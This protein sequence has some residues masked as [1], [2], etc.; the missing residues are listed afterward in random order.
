M[1][2]AACFDISI[3]SVARSRKIK[4]TQQKHEAMARVDG[5][6]VGYWRHYTQTVLSWFM[7]CSLGGRAW[8]LESYLTSSRKT[9]ES[10]F[11]MISIF[12]SAQ[13]T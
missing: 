10:H 8:G 1:D 11:M 7:R 6:F 3:I 2:R 13:Q 9:C 5:V 12:A 4:C